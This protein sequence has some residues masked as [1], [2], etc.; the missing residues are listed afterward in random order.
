MIT[1]INVGARYP[2]DR[3]NATVCEKIAANLRSLGVHLTDSTCQ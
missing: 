2:I 1:G 3:V